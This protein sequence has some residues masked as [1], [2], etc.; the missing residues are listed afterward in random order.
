MWAHLQGQIRSL[1]D[2]SEANHF[3]VT[4][5]HDSLKTCQDKVHHLQEKP[6]VGLKATPHLQQ[7]LEQL[8]QDTE[9][10]KQRMWVLRGRKDVL[11]HLHTRKWRVW[12]E[13]GSRLTSLVKIMLKTILW[14]E[15]WE[16]EGTRDAE[17]DYPPAR[18]L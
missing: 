7:C 10:W 6:V 8:C 17:D 16:A 15:P 13:K 18:L 2:T 12:E 3:Q 4:E 11:G 5:A 9:G 1:G 14:P